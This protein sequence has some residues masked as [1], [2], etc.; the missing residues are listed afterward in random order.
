MNREESFNCEICGQ[1]T[2]PERTGYLM[3][4][5]RWQDRLKIL[6]WNEE[7]AGQEGVHVACGAEHVQEL[8]AHWM[9]TGSL[10]YP[11]AEVQPPARKPR[12]TRRGQANPGPGQPFDIG[13]ATQLGELAVHRESLERVLTE[14]PRALASILDALMAALQRLPSGD[15]VPKRE[16]ESEEAYCA[17]HHA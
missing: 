15:A 17:T 16:E 12:A 6:Q 14:N 11:F 3:A 9:A 13:K 4:A 2:G 5:S 1:E 10:E 8:V 7:V